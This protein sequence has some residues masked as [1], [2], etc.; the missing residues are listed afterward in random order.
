M[1]PI[2]PFEFVSRLLL[3][4]AVSVTVTVYETLPEILLVQR[5]VTQAR[6]VVSIG[7]AIIFLIAIFKTITV[8]AILT[9][10]L[11][12]FVVTSVQSSLTKLKGTSVTIAIIIT[13]TAPLVTFPIALASLLVTFPIALTSLLVT[14]PVRVLPLCLGHRAGCY[15]DTKEER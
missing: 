9:A 12:A 10:F 11:D 5:L 2:P 4:T 3:V 13:L 14:L 6:T 7:I 1:H 8:S 15:S